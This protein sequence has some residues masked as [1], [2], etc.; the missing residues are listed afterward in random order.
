MVAFA[1][2]NMSTFG[3]LDYISQITSEMGATCINRP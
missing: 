3:M 1:E 2:L